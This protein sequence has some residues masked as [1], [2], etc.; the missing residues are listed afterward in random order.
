MTSGISFF[1]TFGNR[2]LAKINLKCTVW[3]TIAD[4]HKRTHIHAD[5]SLGL[6]IYCVYEEY[7]YAHR[8][9]VYTHRTLN[10]SALPTSLRGV[11]WNRCTTAAAIAMK[12]MCNTDRMRQ[13]DDARAPLMLATILVNNTLHFTVEKF[14]SHCHR[15][16]E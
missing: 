2:S 3:Y 7:I 10:L 15:I 8:H 14:Q 5:L 1:L 16:T 9:S 11:Q 6:D 4:S 13:N 12:C